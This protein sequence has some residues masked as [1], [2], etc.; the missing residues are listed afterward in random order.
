MASFVIECPDCG[1]YVEIGTGLFAKKRVKC[2]CGHTI[3]A[4]SDK[5]TSK[6]CPHCGNEVIYD[7]SKGEDAVCPVCHE[8]IN[9]SADQE[10]KDS[11]PKNGFYGYEHTYTKLKKDLEKQI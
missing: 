4:N 7:Q 2:A 3:S 8:K 9:T 5:M 10:L 11:Y 1:R 6:K